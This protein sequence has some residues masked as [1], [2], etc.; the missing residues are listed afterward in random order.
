[1]FFISTI[2]TTDITKF[3][4]LCTYI[5][6]SLASGEIQSEVKAQVCEGSRVF[7]LVTH[8]QL[9]QGIGKA[10]GGLFKAPLAAQCHAIFLKLV[11]QHHPEEKD[12][13]NC[14]Q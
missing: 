1:M 6:F 11:Q 14:L 2:E 3:F 12:L 13:V 5:H 8:R 7:P 4:P 10:V 9:A